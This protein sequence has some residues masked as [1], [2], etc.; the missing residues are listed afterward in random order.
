MVVPFDEGLSTGSVVVPQSPFGHGGLSTGGLSTGGL[1]T[2]GLSTGGLSTGLFTEGLSTGGLSTG[3]V[4]APQSPFGHEGDVPQF[5]S[6][7]QSTQFPSGQF[8]PQFPSG[9]F[10]PQFPS[11]QSTQ[12]PSGQLSPQFPSGQSTQFPSGQFSPQFPSGQFSTHFPSGQEASPGYAPKFPSGH[13]IPQ[14]PSGHG[15]FKLQ[16]LPVHVSQL[17]HAPQPF[18]AQASYDCLQ[19]VV[20]H[21]A[22]A[23]KHPARTIQKTV[24]KTIGG[25][26]LNLPHMWGGNFYIKYLI[27]YVRM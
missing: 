26:M 16:L 18:S 23:V 20:S 14:F 19:G 17:L 9:Q 21:D 3:S 8:S 11:G 4:V 2:E 15:V 27:Q 22:E 6:G 25:F 12:F 10:S 7:Q 5:P 1:S 13:C 24:I